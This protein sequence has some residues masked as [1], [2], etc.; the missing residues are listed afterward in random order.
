MRSS[1]SCCSFLTRFASSGLPGGGA[2]VEAAVRSDFRSLAKASSCFLR[3]SRSCCSFLTR[4]LFSDLADRAAAVALA[5]VTDNCFTRLS[6]VIFSMRRI[7]LSDSNVAICAWARANCR[8]SV[9]LLAARGA[10]FNSANCFFRTLFS[11]RS[12][13]AASLSAFKA[14]KRDCVASFSCASSEASFVCSVSLRLAI[15]SSL[16]VVS[17]L[18]VF[19]ELGGNL[20]N[21]IW[22]A[23]LS[24]SSASAFLVCSARLRLAFVRACCASP[25]ACLSDVGTGLALSCSKPTLSKSFSFNSPLILSSALPSSR[26]SDLA[27]WAARASLSFASIETLSSPKRRT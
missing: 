18:S 16:R 10:A 25:K 7:S 4:L 22:R 19:E 26:G 20:F 27:G 15:S 12:R 5:V 3:S 8:L 11:A 2:A 6:S 13:V 9:P 23:V 14:F 17:I 21:L 1:R 24:F